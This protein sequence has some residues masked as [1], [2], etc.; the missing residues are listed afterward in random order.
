ML[1]VGMNA[2]SGEME[3][4]L[5]LA[6]EFLLGDKLWNEEDFKEYLKNEMCI[7]DRGKAGQDLNVP[8]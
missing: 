5:N 6:M 3:S 4:K 1:C 8:F 2:P 7:R